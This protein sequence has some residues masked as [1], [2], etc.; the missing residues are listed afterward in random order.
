MIVQSYKTIAI[1]AAN[2]TLEG[3]SPASTL[4]LD[5]TD[6][7]QYYVM[8]TAGVSL[9][10]SLTIAY[11]GAGVPPTG[12]VGM[13]F[14]PGG[15]TLGVNT[16]T[17]FGYALS[18]TEALKGAV[19][20]V[21][22]D[23]SAFSV[24]VLPAANATEWIET[25]DIAALA[26]TDAK[27]AS[28]IDGSKVSVGSMPAD[29]LA[30]ASITN[31]QLATM[32]TLT[33][34]G[35]NTGGAST[36]ID[37]T[38][39]QVWVL[40]GGQIFTAA[41]GTSSFVQN[42]SGSTAAGNYAGA[43]GQNNVASGLN[44]FAQGNGNTTSGARSSA[45]GNANVASGSN[46]RATGDGNTASGTNSRS[47]GTGSVASGTNSFAYGES[48]T[49]SGNNSF[50]QGEDVTA[51]RE[52]EFARNNVNT[53][54]LRKSAINLLQSA[55]TNATPTVMFLGDSGLSFNVPTNSSV[56]FS[57]LVNA[58]QDV[59]GGG[60]NAGDSAG[61]HLTGV[62]KNVGGTTSL[63]NGINF[64]TTLSRTIRETGTAQ[65][66]ASGTI[67][68]QA[69]ATTVT[70]AFKRSYIYIISGTGAGQSREIIAYNGTTKVATVTPNW[71]V[72]PDNTSVYRIVTQE[73]YE[74]NT[75]SWDV[76]AVANNATDT[77]DITV[78]GQ[79]S[80][81]IVWYC[82]LETIE[83]GF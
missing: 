6:L 56:S 18:A 75:I 65:S 35:N 79:A 60:G 26:V 59:T 81:N 46:S 82:R 33:I 37:L 69:S 29:R 71:G 54:V 39:A 57:A 78:T 41:A 8:T 70:D 83:L 20:A 55:T 28:G 16:F 5:E 66:G 45:S 62:I 25:G 76:N 3:G 48:A 36:P 77:L 19:I 12:L 61:W 53:S 64:D 2:L 43:V 47:G 11:G 44:S 50:A 15:V 24:S 7:L 10:S 67:T 14:F 72:N 27:I 23:G 40:L 49:A 17:I 80:K 34:K 74:A 13:F 63:V 58:V 51:D 32:P 9:S 73:H 21:V 30:A 22:Y 68:L 31:A 38:A 52:G 1:A 42:G 4:N